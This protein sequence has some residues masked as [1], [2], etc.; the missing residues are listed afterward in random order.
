MKFPYLN[1]QISLNN[2]KSQSS[3]SNSD[4]NTSDLLNLTIDNNKRLKED[5]DNLAQ[6]NTKLTNELKTL[7]EEI[8]NIK[9]NLSVSELKNES[10]MGTNVCLTSEVK[11]WKDRSDA[12]LRGSDNGQEWLKIQEELKEAQDKNQELTDIINQL[13]TSMSDHKA[14]TEQVERDLE[15]AKIQNNADKAKHQQREEMFK[16]LLNELREIVTTCQKELQLTN[17]DWGIKGGADRMKNVKE[18][19]STIKKSIIDKIK[20]DRDELKSKIKLAEDSQGELLTAQKRTEESENKLKE[21]ETRIGQMNNVINASKAKIQALQKEIGDLKT[22]QSNVANATAAQATAAAA[23]ATSAAVDAASLVQKS[24]FDAIKSKLLQTHIEN[25]KLKKELF[26]AQC[27]STSSQFT[28]V[29]APTG[30]TPSTSSSSNTPSAS[31]SSNLTTSPKQQ[32]TPAAVSTSNSNTVNITSSTPLNPS[33]QEQQQTPTAYIAPSRI[34]KIQP[35]QQQQQQQQQPQTASAPSSIMI[36]RT[37]AVQPQPH[38]SG[39]T[40]QRQQYVTPMSASNTGESNQ[41]QAQSSI[42]I[43]ENVVEDAYRNPAQ[44]QQETPSTSSIN[45]SSN[46]SSSSSFAA[47][48]NREDDQWVFF[49]S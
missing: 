15:A 26:E 10:L 39:P 36:R 4:E 34:N 28:N 38:D 47:K 20:S 3:L 41:A 6:E 22:Q 9:A 1:K 42:N 11:R 43:N 35:S 14:K 49:F 25:E 24:D 23:L 18:E 37:A 45:M 19:L 12:F 29:S 7:E 27:K 2:S 44:Q 5:Y 31:I 30:N 8:S 17:I 33:N 13:R 46:H 16:T 32:T 21:K 40:N 48:R